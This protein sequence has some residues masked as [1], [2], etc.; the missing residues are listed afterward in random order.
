ML[1]QT[2]LGPPDDADCSA[3]FGLRQEYSYWLSELVESHL[4]FLIT[5]AIV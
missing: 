5:T 1:D 4:M 3:S 2:V